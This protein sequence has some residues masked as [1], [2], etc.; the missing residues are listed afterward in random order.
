MINNMKM[1]TKLIVGFLIPI[2]ITLVNII[3]GNVTTKI[4]ASITDPVK[5][6]EFKIFS[7]VLTIVK[8]SK[9]R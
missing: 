8:L 7:T 1:K 2:F 6:E 3:V 5:A 4:A 9:S